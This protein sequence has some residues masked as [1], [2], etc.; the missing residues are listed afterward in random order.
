[1]GFYMVHQFGAVSIGSLQKKSSINSG[2]SV[3]FY[4][5]ILWHDKKAAAMRQHV[6]K[7]GTISG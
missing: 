7:I 1:M 5:L 2:M 4:D 6:K 3:I